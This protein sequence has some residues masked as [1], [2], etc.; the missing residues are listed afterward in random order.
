MSSPA[1][2]TAP[3][4]PML[5]GLRRAIL[6]YSQIFSTGAQSTLTYRWNFLFRSLMSFVPLI[7]SFYL[8]SAVFAAKSDLTGY[9]YSL[10]MAYY[11]SLVVHD[12]I[13][14]PGD[15][16]FQVAEDIKEGRISMALI[17]PMNFQAY[18]FTLH[19]AAICL[20]FA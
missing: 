11:I 12:M 16:D 2:P 10:M 14:W 18:R 13:T 4:P 17:K 6:L 5:R 9:S 19:V 20:N 3:S 7:G 1:N 8:W 15:Q